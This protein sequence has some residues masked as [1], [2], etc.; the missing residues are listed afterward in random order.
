MA[1]GGDRDDSDLLPCPPTLCW[2]QRTAKRR[3]GTEELI[4]SIEGAEG[5]RGGG[6]RFPWC[7]SSLLSLSLSLSSTVDINHGIPALVIPLLH[8]IDWDALPP[9][10]DPMQDG[11]IRDDGGGLSS[12][13][14]TC[15]RAQVEAFRFLLES[16][17]VEDYDNDAGNGGG[18]DSNL[19]S[20]ITIVNAGCSAGNLAIPLAGLLLNLNTLNDNGGKGAGRSPC[21]HHCR[22][23]GIDILTVDVN[24]VA[25]DHLSR[26]AAGVPGTT[27]W[28]LRANLTDHDLVQLRVPPSNVV[29]IVSLHACGAASDMAM[30]LASC[31]GGVPF[32]VCP[33][34]TAKFLA[35]QARASGAT[36]DGDN[37]DDGKMRVDNNGAAAP[38]PFCCATSSR[39]HSGAMANIE[40]PRS[41]WLRDTFSSVWLREWDII[42]YPDG[43][44]QQGVNNDGICVDDN[45]DNNNDKVGGY[46]A[47]LAKVADVGL[48]PQTPSQQRDHQRQAKRIVELDRP[49]TWWND[50]GT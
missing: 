20:G 7:R 48:R 28:T 37:N 34:C 3:Q 32:V 43:G 45:D 35:R 26:R 8:C 17:M 42:S 49:C 50:M 40:Y 5:R 13:C 41:V 46:Y 24:G 9:E 29:M 21:R 33:C 15:K 14:G 30:D 16:L 1:G 2:R 36:G 6:D 23:R 10:L 19:L 44:Q 27:V 31:C 39:H 18:S 22:R 38:R 4:R 25:L 47:L 12:M 11:G